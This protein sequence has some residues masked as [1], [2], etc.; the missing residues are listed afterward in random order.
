MAK[1][2]FRMAVAQIDELKFGCCSCRKDV[3]TLFV[4]TQTSLMRCLHALALQYDT[5][6]IYTY[7]DMPRGLELLLFV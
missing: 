7:L 2:G 1:G 4:G 6:R 3:F 5:F